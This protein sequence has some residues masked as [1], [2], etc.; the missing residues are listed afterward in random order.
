[1]LPFQ[2]LCNPSSIYQ[3]EGY[4]HLYSL[5][6]TKANISMHYNLQWK[7]EGCACSNWKLWK[8]RGKYFTSG[9]IQYGLPLKESME[10]EEF[11][12]FKTI[13]IQRRSPSYKTIHLEILLPLPFFLQLFHFTRVPIIYVCHMGLIWWTWCDRIRE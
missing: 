4:S 10:E 8:E 5:Q 6:P 12:C 11:I 3:Q 1:M 7:R 2:E 9:A 13:I